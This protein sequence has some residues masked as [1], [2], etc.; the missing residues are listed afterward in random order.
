MKQNSPQMYNNLGY[1]KLDKLL[2]KKTCQKLNLELKIRK[3]TDFFDQTGF[4]LLG[5]NA[6]QQIP[7]FNDVLIEY[8]IPEHAA[9]LLNLKSILLFQDL[10]IWK[11]PNSQRR[12]E[13]HQDYSYWP[14]AAPKGITIWIALD[15]SSQNSGA[16]RYIPYSNHWGECQPTVYT[17]HDS[18]QKENALPILP[19]KQNEEKGIFIPR[20]QGDGIAHHPLS[21]HCSPVN[22][23]TKHRRAWS[24]TFLDPSV[25]W[26]PEHAPHPLNHQLNIPRNEP[27]K[28]GRFPIFSIH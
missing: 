28:D 12:V 27:L 17:M 14:L 7:L 11:P 20:K 9:N 18:Y 16:L 13:W 15:E 25:G 24:I 1:I 10:V 6:W 26:D 8:K 2:P 3:D 23:S 19:W 21:C 22:Q 4:G 5:Q